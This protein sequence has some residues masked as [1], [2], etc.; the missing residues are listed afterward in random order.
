MITTLKTL[1]ALS[2]YLAVILASHYG[3][4]YCFSLAAKLCP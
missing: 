4:L 2:V 1:W 3:T